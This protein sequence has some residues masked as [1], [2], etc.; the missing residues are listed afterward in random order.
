MGGVA[1]D[2][3]AAGG[4]PA[5]ACGFVAVYVGSFGQLGQNRLEPR[6]RLAPDLGRQRLADRLGVVGAR[7]EHQVQV[8]LVARDVEHAAVCRQVPVVHVVAPLTV[9]SGCAIERG[10]KAEDAVRLEQLVAIEQAERIANRGVDSVGADDDVGAEALAV[11]QEQRAVRVG[12]NRSRVSEHTHYGLA[13]DIDER[14]VE[15]TARERDHSDPTGQRQFTPADQTAGLV[16]LLPVAGL[17]RAHKLGELQ[18]ERPKR[19][20]PVLPQE[21]AGA[22][23]LRARAALMHA[24]GP[25]PLHERDRDR[26]ARKAT[27]GNLGVTAQRPSLTERRPDDDHVVLRGDRADAL[28][29]HIAGRRQPMARSRHTSRLDE[30]REP[31]GRSHLKRPSTTRA[32]PEGM[33]RPA[34]DED[35]V[36]RSRIELVLATPEPHR[37]LEQIESL[38]LVLVDMQRRGVP[39]AQLALQ[40]GPPGVGRGLE[41]HEVAGKPMSPAI[42]SRKMR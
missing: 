21:D 10:E 36:A 34:R 41:R 28:H 5:Y 20:E 40:E 18:P 4:P 11:C 13:R 8:A 6:E 39:S 16:A 17:V 37:P 12:S 7:G 33:R 14:A 3:H 42:A 25:P 22:V 19:P 32:D 23:R 9:A 29:V 35:K 30:A 1:D 26:Q 2:R 24:D 27:A 38:V 15:I 31:A